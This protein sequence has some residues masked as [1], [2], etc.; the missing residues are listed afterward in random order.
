M[1][2]TSQ[3]APQK[4]PSIIDQIKYDHVEID[5]LLDV[6]A[7]KTSLDIGVRTDAL[8]RAIT[9]LSEHAV[10]EEILLYPAIRKTAKDPQLADASLTEHQRI[11]E[12]ADKIRKISPTDPV[13]APILQGTANSSLFQLFFF[14]KNKTNNMQNYR[15]RCVTM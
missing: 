2:T 9:L 4:R 6:A 10:A 3:Q 14:K 15:Q 13:F 1:S 5:R 7:G 12:L 8:T 11:K